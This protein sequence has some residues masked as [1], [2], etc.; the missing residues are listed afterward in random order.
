MMQLQGLMELVLCL[1][2]PTDYHMCTV[3][4]YTLPEEFNALNGGTMF[5]PDAYRRLQ[6]C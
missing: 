3:Q 4:L 6:F 5:L 1:R 2:A